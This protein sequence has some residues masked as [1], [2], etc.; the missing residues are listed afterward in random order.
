MVHAGFL[1]GRWVV[2]VQHSTGWRTTYEGVRPIVAEGDAVTRGQRIGSMHL[3]G[4]HCTCLHWGLR[5]GTTYAD[6]MGLLRRP[7]VLKPR[8]VAPAVN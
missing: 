4:T 5:K 2:S 7:V 6:P 8:S 3:V 1:A